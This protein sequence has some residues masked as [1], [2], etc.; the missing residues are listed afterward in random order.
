MHA[1]VAYDLFK[2]FDSND[3]DDDV[4]PPLLFN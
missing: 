3:V 4:F 2:L 1:A